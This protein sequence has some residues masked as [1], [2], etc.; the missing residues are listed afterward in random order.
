MIEKVIKYKVAS[1]QYTTI[2]NSEIRKKLWKGV[3][4]GGKET[5]KDNNEWMLILE[6]KWKK[7]KSLGQIIEPI[8]KRNWITRRGN[9][10]EAT[11]KSGSNS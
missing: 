2:I 5:K 4:L 1:Y 8:L 11:L 6:H 3:W 10:Y 7:R 9:I